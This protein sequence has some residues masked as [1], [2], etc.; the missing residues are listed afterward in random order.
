LSET[1]EIDRPFVILIFSSLLLVGM[2]VGSVA[3]LY[4]IGE[5]KLPSTLTLAIGG[6]MKRD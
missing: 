1:D 3:L 4:T 5:T 6:H 2:V